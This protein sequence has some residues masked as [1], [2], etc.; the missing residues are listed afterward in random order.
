MIR[1]AVLVDSTFESDVQLQGINGINRHESTDQTPTENRISEAESCGQ[2]NT[3][4]SG[5]KALLMWACRFRPP[6]T[7]CGVIPRTVECVNGHGWHA[8]G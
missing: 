6:A 7:F 2:G 3:R 8:F 1:E 5:G 4:N